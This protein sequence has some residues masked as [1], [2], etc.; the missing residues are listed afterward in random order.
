MRLHP[1][2]PDEE[3]TLEQIEWLTEEQVHQIHDQVMNLFGGRRGMLHP[4]A[5]PAALGACQNAYCD[6]IVAHAARL[7]VSLAMGH[8]FNDGNKRTAFTATRV[9]LL[10]NGIEY[11]HPQGDEGTYQFIDRHFPEGQDSTFTAD[12]ADRHLTQY[13]FVAREG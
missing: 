12:I 9:F 8:A 1:A 4:Y 7:W 3:V 5:V 6:S 11:R 2:W 10:M 13:C